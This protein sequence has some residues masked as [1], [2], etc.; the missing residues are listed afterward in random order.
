MFYRERCTLCGEC[1][2]KCPYLAYPKE[3]AI[4]EFEKL[5]NGEDTP[6]TAECIT[7]ARCNT[8]CPENANPFDLINQRQEE[9]GTF[10]I[11]KDW[12]RMMKMATKF[13][14][15]IIKGDP[16]K[17]L[18]SLCS[19]GD[20]LPGVIEGELFDGLT[21]LMGGDYFCYF[22]FIHAGKPSELEK[23]AQQFVDN[24]TKT[25]AEEIIL[26][27]D[28]CY[29]MLQK[30]KEFDIDVSFKPIHIIEYLKNYVMEHE[31]KVKKL[32]IKV[33]YQAPCA[34]RYSFDKHKTLDELFNLIGVERVGRKYDRENALCCASVIGE[35]LNRSKE[36]QN[37]WKMKNI[38]DAKESGAEAFVFLCPI[39]VLNLRTRAKIQGMEPYIISN[40]VRLSLGE[41][42][43]YGGAGKIYE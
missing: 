16:N 23:H 14:S 30:V 33:A 31:D 11:T 28:D 13:P 4:I 21:I 7:C 1:L 22:G 37:E 6:V 10:K 19:V 18:L 29:A 32:N 20:I 12:M 27:H 2:V 9:T 34:S 36:E 35:M 17:P 38:M 43:P 41:S 3:K 24:L 5:I 40:L 26:Y 42:L 39:C 8:I 15:K 25:G